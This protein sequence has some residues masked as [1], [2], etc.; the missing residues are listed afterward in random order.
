[1]AFYELKRVV[2]EEL[3]LTLPSISKPFEVHT[4]AS[5]IA[6]GEVLM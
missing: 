4:N 3:V 6:L 1:M 2:I 5:D